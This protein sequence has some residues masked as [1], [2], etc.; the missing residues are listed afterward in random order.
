VRDLQPDL[1]LAIANARIA[2]E[3]DAWTPEISERFW[4]AFAK[5]CDLIQPTTMDCLAAAH[6]DINP[7][8]MWLTGR[9]PRK[10]SL[11]ERSSRRYL[12]ALFFL[13][14]P[15]VL[16]QLYVWTCNNL[17]KRIEDL[18]TA[19]KTRFVALSDQFISLSAATSESGHLWTPDEGARGNK[20]TNES[21][22][23]TSDINRMLYEANMLAK[24]SISFYSDQVEIGPDVRSGPR[25]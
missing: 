18:A 2:D 25:K 9:T 20:I 10:I 11:A 14:I 22:D 13:I 8:R 4:T 7:S 17:S 5:L 6:R 3:N 21:L 24:V 12:I 23:L 1:S 19:S 16:V 15:L